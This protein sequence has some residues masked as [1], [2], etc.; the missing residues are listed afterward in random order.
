MSEPNLFPNQPTP[1]EHVA[2]HSPNADP[3]APLNTKI[4]NIAT[5]LKI[6]EERQSSLRKKLQ[7]AESNII[8]VEKDSYDEI[9][10]LSSN[11]LNVKK[12]LVDLTEKVSLLTDEVENF[13]P[14][15]EFKV[16]EKY[17]SFW[18]PMDFVTRKEVNDFLR[19]K[20]SGDKPSSN[21]S[22]R[23]VVEEK[24]NPKKSDS[25]TEEETTRKEIEEIMSKK[26]K[27]NK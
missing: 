2:K 22:P 27:L 14:M 25:E 19:K 6:L 23:K 5:R 21:E 20:F 17:I 8:E 10:I 3:L 15:N 16:L 11:I 4:N 12:T 26:N 13:V 18:Q 7:L 1:E 9:Q 24:D